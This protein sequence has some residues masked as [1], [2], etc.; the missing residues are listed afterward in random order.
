MVP[1]PSP[2]LLM[3]KSCFKIEKFKFKSQIMVI[4]SPLINIEFQAKYSQIHINWNLRS[5]MK[6]ASSSLEG[7]LTHKYWKDFSYFA[8]VSMKLLFWK[9]QLSSCLRHLEVAITSLRWPIFIRWS[10][11]SRSSSSSS[12]ESMSS[13]N[14]GA[15]PDSLIGD[16]QYKMQEE[17][18]T[19]DF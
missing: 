16:N 18:R 19:V 7:I 2:C 12:W 17:L 9:Y 11:T 5:C 8:L 10:N 1:L 4:Q 13:I 6:F 14:A 3:Q 15:S